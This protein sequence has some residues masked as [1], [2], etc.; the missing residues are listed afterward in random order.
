MAV[1]KKAA[2]RNVSF[3]DCKL[4]GLHFEYCNSF[5]FS[6]TF[7]NCILNLSSF[8]KLRLKKTRFKNCS[9]QEVDF[10]ECD[11]SASIFDNCD[12]ARAKFE[13]TILK[14]ADFRTSYNYSIDPEN[15]RITKAK[16]SI[17]GIVGLLDKYDIEVR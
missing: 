7:Q 4:L 6:V 16:F 15:N 12:L 3:I 17:T 8:Y 13:R 1:M 11:L 2:M 5:S 10:A 14:R 9:L